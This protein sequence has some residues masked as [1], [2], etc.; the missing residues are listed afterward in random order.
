[1]PHAFRRTLS[2]R[3]LLRAGGVALGLPLLEAMAP[4]ARA[5]AT[6]T[7]APPR[8]MV[9]INSCLGLYGP[10]FFPTDSGPGYTLSPYLRELAEWRGDFTVMSG[11]SHPE[12]GSGHAS[13][14]SFLTSA[15]HANAPSFRNTISVDQL[16]AEHV[17]PVVR[18]PYLALG[19]IQ[20]SLSWTRNG[21]QIPSDKDPGVVFRRLFIA[22]TPDEVR[23]QERLLHDGQSVLDSVR[24]E[25]ASLQRRVGPDDRDRLDQYFTAVREVEQRLK[26]SAAWS[27]RPRPRVDVEPPGP[28]APP[29]DIVARVAALY[30]LIH[31][32]LQTDSTRIVTLSIDQTGGVPPIDG[33]TEGYHPLSHHGMDPQK[34]EQLRLI[35][36]AEV[37]AFGVLLGKLK[38]T[39]EAGGSLLDTTMALYGSNLGNASS[40]DPTNLPI[41][42]AGGGFAHGRHLAFDR[43]RNTPLANL[44]VTMLQRFGLETDRFGSSVGTLT[45]LDRA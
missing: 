12:V 29:A 21:V 26:T 5:G 24:A 6:A 34:I 41:L 25:T 3:T 17:G 16:A 7:T 36:R 33:V 1:M 2:R 27:R 8:R 18:Y 39:A 38:R 9:L 23:A 44:F 35:E 10:D 13:E 32:A 14:A 28:L 15:P 43:R 30:D 40:H 20:S 19:T 31:L 22:G 11:L 45:G 37:R 42:I 4:R